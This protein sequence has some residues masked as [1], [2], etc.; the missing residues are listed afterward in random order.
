MSYAI[1]GPETCSIFYDSQDYYNIL[2]T[3]NGQTY[4]DAMCAYSCDIWTP[5]AAHI[6]VR[7]FWCAADGEQ[8]GGEEQKILA[9]LGLI[10]SS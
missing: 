2:H 9:A 1:W 8:T 6:I 7:V 3:Y 4:F 5:R 10:T